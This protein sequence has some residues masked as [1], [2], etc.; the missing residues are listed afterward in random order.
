M[1]LFLALGLMTCLAGVAGAQDVTSARL[2]YQTGE[3]SDAIRQ[4]RRLVGRQPSN[5]EVV[6][7][8]VRALMVVGRYD[9]AIEVGLDA[10]AQ[11]AAY[12]PLGEALMARGRWADAEKAFQ[13]ALQDAPDS[14]TARLNLA[15]LAQR[16]GELEEA[17]RGFDHFIDVYNANRT[18]NRDDFKG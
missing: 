8:L 1:K 5:G 16:R 9:D 17:T 11:A 4:Y 14:L 3:Y 13:A 7:G 12:N 15:L 18:Q 10:P 6:R 2:A